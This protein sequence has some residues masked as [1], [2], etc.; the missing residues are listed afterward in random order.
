M[1]YL[2]KKDTK[3]KIDE[4]RA[5]LSIRKQ[6]TSFF[7][8]DLT[9]IHTKMINLL[10]FCRS[11]NKMQPGVDQNVV[12]QKGQAKLSND[13]S[14]F[15]I[16]QT[17]QKLKAT[18]YVLVGDD[19]KNMNKIKEKYFEDNILFLDDDDQEAYDE[20]KSQF[21]RFF[22]KDQRWILKR[23]PSDE[24]QMDRIKRLEK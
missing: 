21:Q 6:S 18:A 2:K 14:I 22:E 8:H 24:N 12:F 20:S 23:R 5:K 11:K 15:N 19:Q 1:Y 4:N 3:E 17:I 13:L 7:T 10:W 16:L 9:T